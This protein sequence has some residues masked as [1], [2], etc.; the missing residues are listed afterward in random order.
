MEIM[1]L[2]EPD[3]EGVLSGLEKALSLSKDESELVSYKARQTV[4]K[5]YEIQIVVKNALRILNLE[6]S[7]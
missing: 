3:Y 2:V 6:Y 5:N 4:I 1:V 7:N